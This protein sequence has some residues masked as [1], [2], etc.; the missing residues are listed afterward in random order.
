MGSLKEKHERPGIP[1]HC[2]SAEDFNERAKNLAFL[3][4]VS[5]QESRE[6]LSNIYSFRTIDDLHR[7]LREAEK[8]PATY[9]SGPYYEDDIFGRDLDGSVLSVK[10]DNYSLEVAASLAKGTVGTMPK[11]FWEIREMGLFCRPER[12]RVLFKKVRAKLEALG[13]KKIKAPEAE[14]TPNAYAFPERS[15][16]DEAILA[17]TAKGAAI[18]ELL[19]DLAEGINEDDHRYFKEL[20]R[21]RHIYPKNPWVGS[22]YVEFASS[23]IQALLEGDGELDTVGMEMA[24]KA[25]A[26]AKQAIVQFETLLG[27][28]C[29]KFAPPKLATF[30]GPHGSDAYYYPASLYW[31]GVAAK[32]VGDQDTAKQWFTRLIAIDDTDYFNAKSELAEINGGRGRSKSRR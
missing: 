31:G 16:C 12:H 32:A 29:K 14:A 10:R 9:L 28:N 1:F 13:L 24:Q 7:D 21:L 27:E 15:S 4:D 30:R 3:L 23:Q 20:E 19:L 11:H 8:S 22:R 17:F 6:V 5:Q 18:Y 2:A 26:C 25:F